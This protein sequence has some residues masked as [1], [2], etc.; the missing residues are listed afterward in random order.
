MEFRGRKYRK[1]YAH[2]CDLTA[3]EW[4]A[5]FSDVETVIGDTLPPSARR[6][7]AWWSNHS[8]D[9][10]LR[11]ARAWIAAGW[12]TVDVDMNAETLLFRRE[13]FPAPL[14][15]VSTTDALNALDQL[16]AALADRGVDLAAWAR[17][18]HT[19]RRAIDR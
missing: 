11:Q 12:E 16:Q 18:L 3:Q 14:G 13:D 17:N 1:L 6:H 10:I 8:G 2:L 5:A 15:S 7:R 4:R 19:E 9:N